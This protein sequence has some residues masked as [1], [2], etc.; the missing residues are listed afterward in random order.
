M[1]TVN[2]C[3]SVLFVVFT[4]QIVSVNAQE[5]CPILPTPNVFK[6]IEGSFRFSNQLAINEQG[7][8]EPIREFLIRKFTR[9]MN[10]RVVFT[11]VAKELQFKKVFNTPRDYYSININDGIIIQYS[12]EESCF[13]AL[14]SLFQLMNEESGTYVFPKCFVQDFPRFQW[15]GLHLDVSRHFF[16]VDEVKRYIDLMSYYKFNVFHWHLTDDQGWRIEIK[17]Y[18]KLTEIGAWRDSTVNAHYTTV[19]RTYTKKRYGGF[20]TQEE[21]KDVVQ[22]AADKYITIVPEIEMPGHSRALLAAYPNL[23]CT[24]EQ[25]EVPGLWGVFDDILCTHE[26]SIYFMKDVLDEV[27]Q[28]F[29]STYI[30]IGGDEAPKTRWKKCKKCQAV[31]RENGLKDE[32]ELQSWFIGRIDD[33]LTS[34]GRSLI[35]WDE[36]LE[37]GLS[38]NAAVMSWRGTEGGIEA[39]KMHHNVVMSPGSHCYFDHY[40]SKSPNEPLAI[41]GYTSLQK[42]YEFNPIPDGLSQEEAG[43][44]LG[45]QANLWTEYIPDMKKLEYMSYPRALALAQVLWCNNKPD[46]EA[47]KRSFMDYHMQLLE[48]KNVNFSRAMFYPEMEVKSNVNG[49]SIHFKGGEATSKLNLE[50]T[51]SQRNLKMIPEKTKSSVGPQ[52]TIFVKRE[53]GGIID[54]D[55]KVK[56]DMLETPSNFKILAHPAIG[57]NISYLTP[58]SEKYKSGGDLTLVDGILGTRPW[59]GNEWVGFSATQVVFTIDA[60][61]KTKIHDLELSFLEDPSAWILMPTS[62]HIFISNDGKKWKECKDSEI[63][64][65]EKNIPIKKTLPFSTTIERKGKYVKVIIDALDKIPENQPGAGNIPWTF[66]DEIILNYE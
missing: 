31:I 61:S 58:P 23:S 27:L 3:L 45:A 39:A 34:K 19:P 6:S 16:T 13:Y 25:L 46:F 53:K 8:P 32:H 15:R 54:F 17:K 7:I 43:Y 9:E 36:I 1:K 18:P 52:D 59:K 42:V 62:V 63:N 40:Q 20:Y 56:S 29:P 11:P 41:G 28:L 38:T 60:G 5:S 44:I 48:S 12:S 66:M 65:T 2:F 49:L 30:H 26:S 22:Y 4:F 55:F 37:G 50:T 14:T 57:L 33:Y 47:F 51:K 64:L 24:G 35:G 21:I 10:T